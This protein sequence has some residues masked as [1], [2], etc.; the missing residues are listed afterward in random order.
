[1]ILSVLFIAVS[2]GPRRI[3]DAFKTV[4]V[5]LKMKI[6]ILSVEIMSPTLV[7]SSSLSLFFF[8]IVDFSL[9]WKRTEG[10]HSEL[11]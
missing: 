11:L 5:F 4:L 7:S 10:L 2:S 1:M 3:V 8:N 6:F 9:I